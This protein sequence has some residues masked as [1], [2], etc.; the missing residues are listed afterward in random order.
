MYCF[1]LCVMI[2]FMCYVLYYDV[3]DETGSRT[4]WVII[5][6]SNSQSLKTFICKYRV[7]ADEVSRY[8]FLINLTKIWKTFC[9]VCSH[10]CIRTL[11]KGNTI[12]QYN[13]S[14]RVDAYTKF[15]CDSL[16]HQVLFR[17]NSTSA[18]ISAINIRRSRGISHLLY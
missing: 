6:I 18:R 17:Y 10:E 14:N 2:L 4:N 1:V 8:V 5:N 3:V 13:K 7:K 9:V 15:K 12:T 11:R 16:T